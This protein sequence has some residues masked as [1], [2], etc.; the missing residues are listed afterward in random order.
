MSFLADG[1][2]E[3][4]KTGYRG[5][6]YRGSGPS[7]SA[8]QSPVYPPKGALAM[9]V[10]GDIIALGIVEQDCHRMTFVQSSPLK[11]GDQQTLDLGQGEGRSFF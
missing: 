10:I 4:S 6:G 3:S 7:G 1:C 2:C 8:A 11:T 9:S 5:V